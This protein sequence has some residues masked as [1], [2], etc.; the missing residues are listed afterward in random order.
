MIPPPYRRARSLRLTP[1]ALCALLTAVAVCPA[2]AQGI[3]ARLDDSTFWQMI[4]DLSEPGGTF[5]SDNFV[6]NEAAYQYVIPGLLSRVRPGGVYLGVGPDQNFTYIAAFVPRI[7]FIVDIRRQNLVQHLMYKALIEDSADRPEFVSR[8]F[9]RPRPAGLDTSMSAEVILDAY[10]AVAPDSAMFRRTL[11]AIRERLLSAHGFALTHEDL[12]SL[13]YV[14]GAFYRAGPDIT[15]SFGSAGRNYGGY[16]MPTY[17]QLMLETDGH[18]VDRSY[19]GSESTY[20]TLKEL[21]EQNLI[22]PLVGDFAG[23][24]A[25]RAV[26]EYLKAHGAAVSI[27]YTSNVEMY[28]FQDPDAWKRFYSSVS[29][30]P[31]DSTST[32]IR[33]LS[34][35]GWVTSQNPNSRSAQLVASMADL[36]DAFAHG[37]I[38]S[39]YSIIQISRY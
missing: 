12:N 27:F 23:P 2:R 38:E 39:Y 20:R 30:L 35:R 3:P 26:G 5:R 32:F 28:L 9:S 1:V 15:Y 6:S 29:T 18:G 11:T 37:R 8:L 17:A 7:A 31:I 24:Q 10:A 4:S 21:E 13:D 16:G 22:V 34:N 19:L 36:V 25:L 14:F 33:S